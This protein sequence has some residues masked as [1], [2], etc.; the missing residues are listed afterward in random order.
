MSAFIPLP[1]ISARELRV[2]NSYNALRF[3]PST[4]VDVTNV[5][6]WNLI[7][8]SFRDARSCRTNAAVPHSIL[9]KY[10]D[11]SAILGLPLT[12]TKLK[13]LVG[14]CTQEDVQIPVFHLHGSLLPVKEFPLILTFDF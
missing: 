6:Y 9:S 3:L 2:K 4:C 1:A 11:I 7:I 12:P 14:D 5:L 13:I 10:S 8:L